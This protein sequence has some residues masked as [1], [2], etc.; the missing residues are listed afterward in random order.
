MPQYSVLG[1][2]NSSY[3]A[4]AKYGHDSKLQQTARCVSHEW[5]SPIHTDQASCNLYQ[6]VTTWQLGPNGL[7][8]DREWALIDPDGRTLSQ[9]RHPS[10]TQIRP[11][12]DP[13]AGVRRR[14]KLRCSTTQCRTALRSRR[15]AIH[16]PVCC[17][18]LGA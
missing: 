8:Y 3:A 6:A 4:F 14:L 7:L 13:A 11:L 10:L 12:V 2:L 15:S 18:H 17:S 5:R 1:L 9:R 16:I